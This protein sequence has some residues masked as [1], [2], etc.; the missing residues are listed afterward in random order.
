MEREFRISA[1]A[2]II[3][4][5][6]VLLVRYNDNHGGSYLVSP[7]GGVLIDESTDRAV[8]REVFEETGIEVKPR[9]ILFVEDLLSRQWRIT[10]IW[11]LCDVLGGT[12]TKTQGAIEEKITEIGWYNRSQLDTEV[13]YPAPL[14]THNW[15]S[16][17]KDNWKTI[18]LDLR[19]A[20]F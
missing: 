5:R 16:F 7:G 12:L 6:K 10:K 3:Q 13:V 18:Y 2:V 4:N 20:D 8:V 11:F 17:S 1:G 9:K 15:D 14:L 19:E